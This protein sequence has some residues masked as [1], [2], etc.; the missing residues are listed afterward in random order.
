MS[1]QLQRNTALNDFKVI[2]SLANTSSLAWRLPFP[3]SLGIPLHKPGKPTGM[4]KVYN[5]CASHTEM[6]I[7]QKSGQSR[8][9]TRSRSEQ[10]PNFSPN[11]GSHREK[12][13]DKPYPEGNS[14]MP[15]DVGT[16]PLLVDRS[17]LNGSPCV[18]SLLTRKRAN[19]S[20][21]QATGEQASTA[22]G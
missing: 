21:R 14:C 6:V 5:L 22:T 19:I 1:S 3:A 2:L 7:L 11:P 20:S 17:S 8:G 12:A 4:L 15:P 10:I 18:G 13:R 9:W 16:Q